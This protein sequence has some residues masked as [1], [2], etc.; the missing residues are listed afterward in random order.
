MEQ[1]ATILEGYSD[2]EKGAYLGAIASI[3]TADTSASQEEI[4]YIS[5]LCESA[6]LSEQQTEEVIQ[7]ANDTTGQKLPQYLDTLKNSELK[8]SLVT[9]LMSFAKS[10]NV[11]APA[12][13]E[14]I[15]KIAQ[16]L[17]IDQ[18]QLSLLN[19]VAEK[20][21]NSDVTPE[22]AGNPDFFFG[23]GLK[24][25]LQKSGIN[26]NGLLKGLLGMAGPM[27]LAKLVRG[28]FSRGG[29]TTGAGSGSSGGLGGALGGVLGGLNPFGRSTSG[30]PGGGGGLGSVISMLNGGRGFG[31]SGGMLGKILKGIF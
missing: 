10:D 2:V 5:A 15:K 30:A 12:E 13:E 1:N 17:Q 25:K 4:D 27:I 16:Y 19:Q 21:T 7:S 3:A 18:Q 20:A 11:Y 23:S 29:S 24:D 22:Q 28:A 26:T 8:Y 14:N 9:D 31:T 6:Q